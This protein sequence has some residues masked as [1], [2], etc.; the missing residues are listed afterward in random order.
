MLSHLV[1]KQSVA[2]LKVLADLL[3]PLKFYERPQKRNYTTQTPLDNLVDAVRPE[4]LT[5]RAFQVGVEEYLKRAPKLGDGSNL[6][7]SL[8][9]WASNH[10]TLEPV[11]E[12]ARLYN[13]AN[14]SRDL[15]AIAQAGLEA[16]KY[17]ESGQQAPLSWQEKA[18]KALARAE[19]PQAEMEIAVISPIRKLTLS[20]GQWGKL[21]NTKPEDWIQSLD[22]QVKAAKR[23]SWE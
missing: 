6:R 5:A 21:K 10:K 12:K 14:Q 18:S 8:D 13:A 9:Q 3:E 7:I 23:K 4:S 15:A 22:A 17:L 16:L 2:R 11:L 19:E 1:G 20:A